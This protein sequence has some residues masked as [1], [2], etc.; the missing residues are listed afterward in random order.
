MGNCRP[1]RNTNPGWPS[2][3]S[4]MCGSWPARTLRFVAFAKEEPAWFW[5]PEMGSLVYAQECRARLD[6]IL[7]MLSLESV[8]FYTDSPGSQRYPARLGFLY[9]PMGNFV[10][11]VGNV[12][13][14]RLVHRSLTAFPRARV[15]PTIGAAVPNAIPGAGWSDHWSFWQQGY[16]GIEITDMAPYRNPYYHSPGDTPD[17]LDYP[18]MARFAAGMEQVVAELA[19][20]GVN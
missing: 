1:Y 4:T 9:P 3:W 20:N 2:N 13:S 6:P 15:L 18:R 5:Q 14:R 19:N 17:R 10:A 11:F 7:A 16:A 8:G 12:G